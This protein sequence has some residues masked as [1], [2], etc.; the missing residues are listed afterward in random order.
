VVGMIVLET[1]R[2]ILRLL[3]LSDIDE[4]MN[5]WGDREVMLYCGGA[6]T[7]EQELKSL[8]YYKDLYDSQG[9]SPF[10]VVLKSD[11]SI[12]GVCGFNPPNNGCDAELM[13]HFKKSCWG[14]G[15]ATEAAKGCLNYAT[16]HPKIKILG[17]SIDPKNDSS[18]N[19]LEKLGFDYVGMK[20]CEA[21]G[22]EE[23]YFQKHV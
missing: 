7:R 9:F 19:V 13:Y 11:Q 10:V 17:A 20:W 5:I 23:P 14:N 12:I 8:I 4:L 21:T 6:G 2:L 15:Y 3:E 16:D 1:E 22:Q 18:R